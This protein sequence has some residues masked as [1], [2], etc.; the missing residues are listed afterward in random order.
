MTQDLPGQ[1]GLRVAEATR[2]QVPAIVELLTDDPIGST[3]ESSDLAAYE[4]AFAAVDADPAHELLVLLDEHDAVVGTLQLSFLPGLARGGAL[5]AHIEAVRVAR[6]LR[7]RGAGRAFFGYAMGRARDRGA[8]LV[9]LTSD[10]RRPDAIRF[11]ES[12]GFTH[13]HAGMKLPLTTS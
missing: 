5:R 12:L 9:E 1:P 7:G 11:Y 13:S 6:S 10:L 3:R 4:N 8:A 2:E